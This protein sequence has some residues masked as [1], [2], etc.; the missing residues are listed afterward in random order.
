VN[1]AGCFNDSIATTPES[2]LAALSAFDEGIHLLL[3]GSK[4][5]L[6]FD[7]LATA[8]ARH[9]GI[10]QVYLQGV[11]ASEIGQALSEQVPVSQYDSFDLACEAAFKAL[12]AGDV[13]LMSPSSASFYEYSAGKKFTNFEHRGR[14]FKQLVQAQPTYL[15]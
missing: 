2:T 11:N 6:S 5:G 12:K 8:I 3:G 7:A 9:K 4:K 14:H 1:G 13:F 15:P 10:K